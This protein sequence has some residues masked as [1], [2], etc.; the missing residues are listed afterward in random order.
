MINKIKNKILRKKL[1]YDQ[2][3]AIDSLKYQKMKKQAYKDFDKLKEITDADAIQK[4]EIINLLKERVEKLEYEL[5]ELKGGNVS[6][7]K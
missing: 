3:K 1:T 5:L 2:Q 6:Y 7:V 4:E